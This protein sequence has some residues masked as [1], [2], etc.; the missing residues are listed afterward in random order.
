MHGS[1]IAWLGGKFVVI[2][3]AVIVGVLSG[4]EYGQAGLAVLVA[5]VGFLLNRKSNQIHVLVDGRLSNALEQIRLQNLTIDAQG[6]R[7]AALESALL[8]THGAPVPPP[9]A[10]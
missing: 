4:N 5:V 1:P 10:P 7:V 6:T 8:L 9:A 3:A 2:D